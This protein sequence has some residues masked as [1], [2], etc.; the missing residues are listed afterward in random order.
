LSEVIKELRKQIFASDDD[1]N[2]GG[3]GIVKKGFET[4]LRMWIER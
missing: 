2:N 3:M 1:P 4:V